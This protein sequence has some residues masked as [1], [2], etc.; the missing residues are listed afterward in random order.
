MQGRM[1]R[2]DGRFSARDHDA[3]DCGLFSLEPKSFLFLARLCYNNIILD[4]LIH[5]S[6]KGSFKLKL[7]VRP[8]FQHNE[9]SQGHKNARDQN[10]KHANKKERH[11][12]DEGERIYT[13]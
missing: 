11:E 4:A 8:V 7:R 6:L 9:R 3:Y 12:I 2:Y 10:S 13:G 1:E 5:G